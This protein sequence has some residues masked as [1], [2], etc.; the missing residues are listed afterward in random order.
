MLRKYKEFIILN[1]LLGV[2]LLI[3]FQFKPFSS[4]SDLIFF[5]NDAKEYLLTATEYFDLSERGFSATRPPLYPVFLA[6][7]FNTGG[8]W[9][10]ISAQLILWISSANLLYFSFKK[11][12]A[13]V[14]WSIF[15]LVFFCANISLLE[16]TLHALTEVLTSFLLCLLLYLLTTKTVDNNEP[17][18]WLICIGFLVALTLIKPVF[19]FT[20]L[21]VLLVGLVYF[22]RNLKQIL[23]KLIFLLLPLL[24]HLLVMVSKYGEFKV[25]TISTLTFERYLFTQ[26]IEREEHLEREKALDMAAEMNDQQKRN[27]IKI[28][29]G[30]LIAI[31]NENLNQNLSIGS[32]MF[33]IQNDPQSKRFYNYTNHLSATIYRLFNVVLI[34]YIFLIFWT[35]FEKTQRLNWT[36]L[37]AGMLYF[38]VSYT[39]GISNYQGD[40][41]VVYVYPLF[42]FLLLSISIQV[43]DTL[44]KFRFPSK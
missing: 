1:F 31:Y 33:T 38:Y 4:A 23:S 34:A 43:K 26:L 22:R 27:Y 24:L 41:L 3:V 39:S 21:L 30:E 8:T 28:H 18:P 11:G 44:L 25:S 20:L 40:R 32:T 19:F 12:K 36:F 16:L 5:G 35:F 15:A 29:F 7:L 17:K 6:V 2:G 42:V 13:H 9:L 14:L 37:M 10:L